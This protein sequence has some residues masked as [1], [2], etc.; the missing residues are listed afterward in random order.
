MPLRIRRVS[1][2]CVSPEYRSRGKR[3]HIQ[4]HCI[5][6]APPGASCLRVSA[7]HGNRHRRN[8]SPPPRISTWEEH[9]P[10]LSSKTPA[11]PP[12]TPWLDLAAVANR[13]VP[14]A[15]PGERQG[16]RRS[17][18]V[19][20]G[21]PPSR[22]RAVSRRAMPAQDRGCT[23]EGTHRLLSLAAIFSA[24][25]VTRGRRRFIRHAAHSTGY[26][27][28]IPILSRSRAGFQ[29]RS[30]RSHRV[31][32]TASMPA[33]PIRTDGT[34]DD[35]RRAWCTLGIS[36]HGESVFRPKSDRERSGKL[37]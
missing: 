6:S 25:S 28:R 35:V 11:S 10:Y 26:R 23:R 32:K 16:D 4:A 15:L 9:P 37:K 31:G 17:R 30:A 27:W 8:R 1:S 24:A 18:P 14:L 13:N 33:D 34:P 36:G 29:P 21:R 5:E 2:S 20:I 7:G 19:V 12:S 3:N 22:I